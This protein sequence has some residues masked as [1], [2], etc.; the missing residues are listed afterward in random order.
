[1]YSCSVLPRA[2]TPRGF[3]LIELLVVI[4]IIGI[5][6]AILFPVFARA[7]ERGY[8]ASCIS[9]QRQ[10]AIGIQ[11][12]AQDNS[13]NLPL[14]GTW[15]DA[16]G[17]SGDAKIYDCPSSRHKGSP[18]DPDYGMNAF[19][20]DLDEG[21]GIAELSSALIENPAAIELTTDIKGMT[22]P[23]SGDTLLDNF[24]NPFPR[25]PTVAGFGLGSNT[26]R[27]HQEAS[28]VSFLDGHVALLKH[29]DLGAGTSPYNIPRGNGRW[30]VDFRDITKDDFDRYMTAIWQVKPLTSPRSSGYV[31]NAKSSTCDLRNGA[32]HTNSEEW[33][34]IG[35]W[36]GLSAA[37]GRRVT[38]MVEGTLTDGAEIQF[39]NN[40]ASISSTTLTPPEADYARF[41]WEQAVCVDTANNYVQFGQLKAY[42]QNPGY[43]INPLYPF[44]AWFDPPA[45]MRGKRVDI[46][47]ATTRLKI[48][49]LVSFV[50]LYPSYPTV[51]DAYWQL[52]PNTGGRSIYDFDIGTMAQGSH[53]TK[54][55]LNGAD[56]VEGSTAFLTGQYDTRYPR[57]L[58][59]Y[60][61]TFKIERMLYSSSN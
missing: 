20:Y 38:F 15:I 29:L 16:V 57:V 46:D 26:E 17:L 10:L 51:P 59:V 33:G 45:P 50:D 39:G 22:E 5:L 54:V 60:N 41:R 11:A 43:P 3:T 58:W 13:G 34:N 48:E 35:C 25:S 19:L 36:M 8:T 42:T 31:Y 56:L 18:S 30:Y 7:R 21:G 55:T 47:P 40:K 2:R 37:K 12:R 14:P 32:L 6:A 49:S 61:G 28:V 44:N 23:S 24:V 1:M 53:K 4:A 27:R 52:R 9:N